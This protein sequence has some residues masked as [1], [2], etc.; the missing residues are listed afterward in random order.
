MNRLDIE[1]QHGS[2]N[3]AGGDAEP[4]LNDPEALCSSEEAGGAGTDHKD[5]SQTREGWPGARCLL[6][7]RAVRI[8][9]DH[10]NSPNDHDKLQYRITKH[11]QGDS[12]SGNV[13]TT[14][15][16][17]FANLHPSAFQPYY[18]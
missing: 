13:R 12:S 7:R 6:P 14:T 5:N 8:V 11:H 16:H 18:T 3:G 10:N 15:S 1:R 4:P 2:S 9:A 17:G